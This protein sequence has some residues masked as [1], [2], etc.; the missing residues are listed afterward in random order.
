MRILASSRKTV[1]DA[2]EP[3]SEGSVLVDL[4]LGHPRPVDGSPEASGTNS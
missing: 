4:N 3:V 1:S 2:S